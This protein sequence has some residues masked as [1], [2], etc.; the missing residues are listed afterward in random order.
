MAHRITIMPHNITLS[1]AP[2]ENLQ[3]VLRRGGIPMS[4]PC[5]GHGT[6]GKCRVLVD[7]QQILACRCMVE[8]DMTVLL[9][10]EEDLAVLTESVGVRE[11]GAGICLAV[12]IGTTTLAAYLTR[13]SRLLAEW[14]G[15]NPQ[16]A[17]GAD[18][19]S[20]I[21]FARKGSGPLLTAAIRGALEELTASLLRQTGVPPPD[22][23]CVVGNPA[24]QQLFL[25]L[26]T[27]NLA[28]PPFR[29]LLTNFT[30]AEGGA[31]IPTWTGA[32]LWT[33][34][35]ISGYVGADTVACVLAGNMDREEPLT[36][37]ADI[38]T[39]AEMV[40]GNRDRLVACA[41]AA[42]PA[43]EAAGIRCGMPA[44]PGAIDRVWLEDGQ[45]HYRVI[46]GGAPRGICGSGLIDA[47]AAALDLGLLNE[48]GKLLTDDKQFHL[49]EG[50]SL[51][52][53]DIRQ[54]QLAKGAF[55]AGIRLM[56]RQMGIDLD[57]VRRVFL[58]G[59]FGTYLN[60]RSA[61][62]IGLLPRELE[63]RITAIGNAAGAG[64]RLMAGDPAA[65]DRAKQIAERT[66]A[67]ELNTLPGF[68]RCFA[69]SMR[70]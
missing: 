21:G 18:V 57:R 29:P 7:G 23:V 37:L 19:I 9:P 17:F 58:A 25:G 26:P 69:E 22:T 41:A 59:A 44:S 38:G 6:C 43:L 27:D 32:T 50:L 2:G 62:R 65:R 5:G 61:C 8:R 55:A 42:G 47:V 11:S 34:P 67:L 15:K 52:Q 46:G 51:D 30:A 33:V 49:A 40:L 13:D 1:A 4:F 31:Y 60:P 45:P 48:R 54:V 14:S 35:N 68:S 56:A 16:A 66:E 24:M 64:A 12:D 3:D 70:F 28:V 39:N 63:G 10:R 53:E 36:L 20:R